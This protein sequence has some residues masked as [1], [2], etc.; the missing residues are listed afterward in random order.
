MNESYIEKALSKE[1]VIIEQ[2]VCFF[3]FII[4]MKSDLQSC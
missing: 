1:K 3:K 4:G 2:I